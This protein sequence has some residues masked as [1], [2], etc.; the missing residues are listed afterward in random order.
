MDDGMVAMKHYDFTGKRKER[1]FD[2]PM[3]NDWDKVLYHKGC[4][5][6]FCAA[7]LHWR[8]ISIADRKKVEYIPVQYDE[9][10][11]GNLGGCKVLI[12]DFSYK[13]KEMVR[14][15]FY[16]ER[17]Q[18]IDHHKSAQ[19]ELK[20]LDEFCIFDMEK[21]G[22]KLYWDTMVGEGN[23]PANWLVEYT[24]DRDLWQWKLPYSREIS[25]ALASHPFHF[26]VWNRLYGYG[27]DAMIA[28]GSAILRYQ[29]GLIDAKVNNVSFVEIGGYVVP[30]VNTTT[31]T[32]EIAGTIA[33]EMPEYPF[34]AGFFILNNGNVRY[35]LR[36]RDDA[37]EAY[38]L[39]LSKIARRYGGGGHP[40]AAGFTLQTTLPM[41][42]KGFT[43][44]DQAP[45]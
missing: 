4:N 43:Q 14:M 5:D 31:L 41:F 2:A 36:M 38:A 45:Q 26:E 17:L 33:E 10:T 20:G 12:L 23:V 21:S 34:A 11:P 32:S 29:Q 1:D 28:E 22:A 27:P 6:G 37:E 7:W 16:T 44:A 40:Q 25:A 15:R 13:H 35:S 30:C 18:V 3:P 39:D 9:E 24:Q 42:P 8:N 19:E